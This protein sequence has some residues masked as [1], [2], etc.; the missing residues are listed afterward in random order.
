[1]T[2][3][4]RLTAF[5][6]QTALRVSGALFGLLLLA[7]SL[8]SSASLSAAAFMMGCLTAILLLLWWRSVLLM[9]V[10]SRDTTTAGIGESLNRISL[11]SHRKGPAFV[12]DTSRIEV[13]AISL[14]L[15]SGIVIKGGRTAARQFMADVLGKSINDRKHGK[16]AHHV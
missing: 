16:G 5:S 10:L 11:A 14:L 2:W 3:R 1:M 15:F 8:W 6:T 7:R 13:E 12:L 9:C 4:P